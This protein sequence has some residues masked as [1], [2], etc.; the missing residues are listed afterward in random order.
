MVKPGIV[1]R[2][3]GVHQADAEIEPDVEWTAPRLHRELFDPHTSMGRQLVQAIADLIQGCDDPYRALEESGVLA[4][5]GTYG[6]LCVRAVSG[7]ENDLWEFLRIT[8][9]L[10]TG[11][12]SLDLRSPRDDLDRATV[13]IF[14]ASDVTPEIAI[15]LDGR[16]RKRKA[17]QRRD[18]LEL[19]LALADGCRVYLVVTV[20]AGRM[21]WDQHRDQLPLSVTEPFDPRMTPSPG[22]PRSVTDRVETARKTLDPDGTASAVLRALRA[23]SSEMLSYDDLSREFGLSEANRRQVVLKLDRDLELA[24]RIDYPGAAVDYRCERPASN[25]STRSIPKSADSGNSPPLRPPQIRPT[26]AV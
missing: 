23:E 6:D 3:D 4:L 25:T 7:I 10:G 18:V 15:H 9:Q 1:A 14:V 21:L 5:D 22:T 24:E 16:F 19:C 20:Q 8:R 26:I 11:Q 17:E 2:R 13:P 12:T